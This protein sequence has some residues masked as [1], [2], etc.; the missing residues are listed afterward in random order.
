M[1]E[2]LR[3]LFMDKCAYCEAA[4]PHG[5]EEVEHFRPLGYARG[6]DS[7]ESRQHY[8]WLAYEW[9]NLLL[10]CGTC[11]K[12]KGGL[13][14]VAGMRARVRAT[15]DEV[16]AFESPELIDPS[17]D[18]PWDEIRMSA[19][20]T[21][22]PLRRRGE[23]TV[24]VFQLNR[25]SL[26]ARRSDDLNELRA[27][28][29]RAIKDG[30]REHL[31]LMFDL[32]RE[33][34]GSRL[35]TL[36]RALVT[37]ASPGV[38][39][40]T[41]RQSLPEWFR[42]TIESAT[43]ADR[44][45]LSDLLE[46]VFLEDAKLPELRP[47]ELDR[48]ADSG[49][50]LP[51]AALGGGARRRFPDREI[52]AVEI[53]DFKGVERLTLE[54]A[55]TTERRRELPCLMLLGENAAGKSSVL[56]AVALALAGTRAVARL[57]IPGS[58]F[59]RRDDP[60][61]WDIIDP[62]A[63][64]VVVHFRDE[65]EPAEFGVS[66]D[67]R[68]LE[69]TAQPSV[70]VLAYGAR[71]Q[72]S[73]N[74][75]PS[76]QPF[77]LIRNLFVPNRALPSAG[78]WLLRISEDETTFNAVARGLRE[79]LALDV[80]DELVMDGAG[81]LSVR[82][83]GRLVPVERLSEG[84]RSLFSLAVDIMRNLLGS[85]PDLERARGVVLIDEIETH[86]HPRW[87]MRIVAALRR[88]FPG[89][90]FII[91]THDPLCL[92]GM[93]NGEV[94]VIERDAEGRVHRL[95]DLPAIRGMSAEQLLTSD[96][97]GLFSTADPELEW[98]LARTVEGSEALR[99]DRSRDDD[100][101]SRIVLGDTIKQQLVHEALD[102]YLEEREQ[103]RGQVRARREAVEAVLKVLRGDAEEQTA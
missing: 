52:K 53:Y 46:D 60:V 12:A 68:R 50:R 87:K 101:I 3:H 51:P 102:H 93:D 45:R 18:D 99:S 79:V 20:G 13:F 88:A 55:R 6:L 73:D 31:S 38:R 36:H 65:G 14:P 39:V 86:L 27:R 64:R 95:G 90:Q 32:S 24:A 91:S 94:E 100:L 33:F 63:P 77:G 82:V 21:C 84:Y 71:R 78:P 23:V 74:S 54:F 48:L 59:L 103:R 7:V 11:G 61:G 26:V 17:R 15:F 8:V 49:M 62:P 98:E 89:V 42:R 19:D 69:G 30:D 43:T 2:A 4:I 44:G 80:N 9:E 37:W 5:E 34:V 66:A 85:W 81:R 1:V 56:E 28:F 29:P 22:R 57:G 47:T 25:P 83:L 92:R 96:Y 35:D 75:R 97:F 70:L 10:V 16:L 41:V 72:F 40:P 58:E 76:R 67:G